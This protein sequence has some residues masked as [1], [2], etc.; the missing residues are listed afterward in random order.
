MSSQGAAGSA[1]H[2]RSQA[3]REGTVWAGN[4]QRGRW[5]SP[6]LNKTKI[7]IKRRK[8]KDVFLF[9]AQVQCE[10]LAAG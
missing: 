6:F 7:I 10:L 1:A 5:S 8:K 3:Q 9:A 2:Q 4:D